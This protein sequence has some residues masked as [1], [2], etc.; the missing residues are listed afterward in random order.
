MARL[1]LSL[2]GPLHVTLDD[3]LVTGFATD[4]VR[5]LLAY[6]ALEARPHR[7][8]A[9]AELLWPEQEAAAAR[10]SLR[11][12]LI[13]LRRA[14]GDQSAQPPFLL[15]TR[16]TVQLSPAS[17]YTLD[18]TTFTGL[19]CESEQHAHPRG[20]LCASCLAQLT[21]AV[22]LYRGE[23]LQQVVVRDSVAYDEWLTLTRERL[24]RL[25]LDALAQLAAY[26]EARGEDEQARQ[27]AWRTLTLEGWDEAAHRCLMRVL[28]RSGQRAAA[29]AQ[30]ERC[31]KVLKEE[32]GVEPAA[33]TTALYEQI[34]QGPLAAAVGARPEAVP[35]NP[36]GHPN[37]QTT[38][39]P[40]SVPQLHVAPPTNLLT[41]PTPLIGRE[42][43]VDTIRALLKRANVRMLTLSGPP[44][45]GKTRLALQAGAVVRDLFADGVFFVPLAPISDPDL[46]VTAI[47]QTLDVKEIGGH[48]LTEHL[49]ATLRDKQLLLVLDNFEQVVDAAPRIAELL[50]GCPALKVLVTSRVVLRLSSEHE[51]SLAPLA[52]PDLQHL[53]PIE[54]LAQTAAVALFVERARAVKPDFA[55]T[56]E[57][58]RAV[59][60]ICARLDGLPLAL[61]LAAARVKLFSP[62]AL[63]ARLERRLNVLTG[64]PR[65]L[66]SRQQTLRSTIDWSYNLLSASEQALFARLGVF[67]SGC[68]LEVAEAVCNADGDLL[69]DVLDG[70]AAL[71]DKSLLQQIEQANGQ[72]RFTMLETIR[73][74]ALERLAAQGEA[75]ALRER[76]LAYYLALAEAAE[77]HL[78][79]AE[80]IVWADR[81][82]VEHDNLRAALAWAHQHG[83][84]DGSSAADAEA[85]LRL[86]G[87]LFWFWDIRNYQIEG[88]RWLEGAL[89]RTGAPA[90]TAARAMALFAAGR[91]TAHW[92]D[93]VAG[94]A[95]LEESVAL[96]RELGDKRGL[97]LALTYANGLGWVA[98][99]ER[100]VAEAR[101][102][103]AE[104]VAL[105]REL[106]DKWGLAMALWSLGA[107]VRRDDPAAA[108]P[109]LE[110]SVA[111]FRD[112]GDAW[113]LMHTR[114]QLGVVARAEGDYMQAG[115]LFE[116]SLAISRETGNKGSLA[117]SLQGL[118]DVVQDQGDY[119]R[120]LV[121][122]QESVALARRLEWREGIARC[123]VGIGGVASAVGQAERAARLLSA[124]ETLLNSI[125]LSVAVWPEVRAG[126]DRYVAAARAQLSEEAFAAAWAAG[127]VMPLEQVIAEALEWSAA[128]TNPA[129]MPQP[130]QPPPSNLPAPPTPLIGREREL[131]DLSALLRREEVR[132]LTLTGAGGSG[133]TRLALELAAAMQDAFPDGVF[134]VELAPVRQA[135]LVAATIATTL[136]LKDAG[137][138]PLL[139]RLITYLQKRRL[140]LLLD[141]FEHVLEAAPL[142]ATL[143]G[144]SRSLKLLITSRAPLHLRGEREVE[145]A[146]LAMPDLQR[147]PSPNPDVQTAAV[148]LFVARAQDMRPDFAL[149]QENAASVNEICVRLDGLPLALELAAARVK[150][151]SPQ[152]LLA[153]LGSRLQLL[154]GGARDLPT[155]QQT[156]RDTITW[157]Y[158]L[159][160]PTEQRLF[161]RLA[162]FVGGWTLE[163]AAAVCDVDGDLGLDVLDG[164]QVLVDQSLVRQE[165]GL[166]GKPRF[167]MLET[168][169]EYA[170]EQLG[171]SRELELLGQRHATFFLTLV[172]AAH[173][174][175]DVAWLDRLEA[176]HANLRAASGWS[177]TEAGGDTGLRLAVALGSFYTERGHLSEGRES[178]TAAVTQSEVGG[179]SGQ[180]TRKHLLLR[181][182]AL[183][184]IGVVASWQ[185]DLA[186][187]QSALEAS[188]VLSRELESSKEIAA[189]LSHLGML[190]QMRGEYDRAGALLEQSL[191]LASEIGDTHRISWCHLFLGILMYSQGNLRRASEL[192]EENLIGFR[193]RDEI[194]GMA[195]AHSYLAMVMLDQGSY[196]QAK[197][198]LRESLTCL[199]EFRDRWQIAFALELCAR[200]AAAQGQRQEEAQPGGLQAARLF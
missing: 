178:V 7:R 200:L 123:L 189:A 150:L 78:R 50:M 149:T 110:E 147:P 14:I 25:T 94:G 82:E 176:E 116:E 160:T 65:D 77:P 122:Y 159:L 197:A 30:Y 76:H 131:A 92:G 63:L 108:R 67:V 148:R 28:S 101:A 173:R 172:E 144:A 114:E 33:E 69:L 129:G 139:E 170:L 175:Q 96:W 37:P 18:V 154:T 88:R 136:G 167:T 17:D 155:R 40:G 42:R 107:A 72:P 61:E 105:W 194:W 16:E 97:A 84:D 47:A 181:A 196:G 98:L 22:A 21:D 179:S 125:G 141:N 183:N 87:A 89:A 157:S 161:R 142:L 9:L 162:V 26:H 75:E 164:M 188:L 79:G 118:A 51:F 143:L 119:A 85:E 137:A 44:G 1:A 99:Y 152:A 56:A 111:L 68:A 102:L 70:L 133:K 168:I 138:L 41:P 90:R 198:H 93:Y 36:P 134:L 156:L 165:Q 13:T 140:L 177:R 174:P 74:Y 80:Q 57:N 100:R 112:V 190:F 127:R 191:S 12:A 135:D 95:R 43:E 35:S 146:P 2:L 34:R 4:K 121:L 62:Q 130:R 132:L 45:V 158:D 8:E 46:V 103:F 199:W 163:T 6:L 109:I 54:A 20:A 3:H 71:V 83:A 145:V 180:N 86:A 124:A 185:G 52:L 153:R 81:L 10:T 66:P 15:A 169:R 60:E 171:A 193:A 126:F 182:Q 64:G 5:A 184:W 187:A 29:L 11:V 151:L 24:H 55:L 106:G 91:L 19:L 23:L 73:E 104:G 192:W 59:V 48:S 53:P 32:L 113:G 186:A 27:Y 120:A 195:S 117:A 49:K 128:P 58:A 39:P 38:I 31:R 166:D 115:L